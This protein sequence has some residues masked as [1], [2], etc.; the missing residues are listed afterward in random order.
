MYG[1]ALWTVPKV[2]QCVIEEKRQF[3]NGKIN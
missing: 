3:E 2:Q 1:K